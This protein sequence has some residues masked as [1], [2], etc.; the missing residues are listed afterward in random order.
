METVTS[1]L[2]S[3]AD[4]GRDGSAGVFASGVLHR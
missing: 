2:E 4:V 3:I 1:L